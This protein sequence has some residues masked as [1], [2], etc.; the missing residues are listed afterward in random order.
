MSLISDIVEVR[1]FFRELRFVLTLLEDVLLFIPTP[2]LINL[3]KVLND[4]CACFYAFWSLAK[5]AKAFRMHPKMSLYVPFY[6]L[7]AR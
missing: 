5:N 4:K 6:H 3:S 7:N 2:G 1:Q